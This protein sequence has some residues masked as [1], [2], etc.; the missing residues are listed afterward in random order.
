MP[1]TKTLQD[2]EVLTTPEFAEL[3]RLH[4]QTIWKMRMAGEGP[5]PIRIGRRVLYLREDVMA[6]L[7]EQREERS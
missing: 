4:K 5:A 6:Y 3:A 1:S 7:R 2:H